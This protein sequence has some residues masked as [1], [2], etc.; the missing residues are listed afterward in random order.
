MTPKIF[1]IGR[2]AAVLRTSRYHTPV[3]RKLCTSVSYQ[4]QRKVAT[5]SCVKVLTCRWNRAI[6][7]GVPNPGSPDRAGPADAAPE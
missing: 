6:P 4:T 5:K 2:V 3:S 1:A 7:I